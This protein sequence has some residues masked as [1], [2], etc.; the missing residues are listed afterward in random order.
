MKK[1]YEN[2]KYQFQREKPMAQEGRK[3]SG[4]RG[5]CVLHEGFEA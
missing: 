3:S 1:L 4:F 2:E 5:T